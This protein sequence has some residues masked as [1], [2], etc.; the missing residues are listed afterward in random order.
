MWR[1]FIDPST[2][3]GIGLEQIKQYREPSLMGTFFYSFDI[4]TEELVTGKT[5]SAVTMNTSDEWIILNAKDN[6]IRTF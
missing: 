3:S 2:A 1:V 4:V 6:L 5:I